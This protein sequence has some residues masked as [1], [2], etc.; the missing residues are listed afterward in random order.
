[1]EK[2][3]EEVKAGTGI[4]SETGEVFSKIEKLVDDLYAQI[5]L[6]QEKIE[7][8]DKGSKDIVENVQTVSEFG[9]TVAGDAQTVS[10]TTEE[11]TAMM[12]NITDASRE[13]VELAQNLQDKVAKFKF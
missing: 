7:N 3:N 11:Q 4:V 10:A 1:M 13:L 6:S 8:A 9:R 5:S 2:G 12:H